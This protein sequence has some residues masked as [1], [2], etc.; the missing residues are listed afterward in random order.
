MPIKKGEQ[1]Y[2]RYTTPQ[3]GTLKRQQ[4]LQSL[5]YFSCDCQRCID[6]TEC[7]SMTNALMCT[8]CSGDPGMVTNANINTLEIYQ[9]LLC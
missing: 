6:P 4:L 9:A 1:I 8:E 2:T 5:W 7:G 3:L